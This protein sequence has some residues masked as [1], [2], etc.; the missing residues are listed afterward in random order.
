MCAGS[1]CIGIAFLK[2]LPHVHVDFAELNPRFI[3]QIT[4]NCKL[5]SI[6]PT[7]YTI[8]QSDLFTSVPQPMKLDF[9]GYDVV[10]ANPPYIAENRRSTVQDSVHRHEDHGSLYSPDDGLGHI[11]RIIDALPTYLAP[12]GACYIEYDPWQTSLIT[13]YIENNH[14]SMHGEIILDQYQKERVVTITF[15]D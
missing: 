8:H 13:E 6:D 15:S 3:E 1:G 7:R 14:P 10:V 11:K 9:P 2:H 4:K 5:N 12:G